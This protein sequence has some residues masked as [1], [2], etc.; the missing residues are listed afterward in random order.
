MSAESWKTIFD[1]GAVALL[2]L[3]FAF[4]AGAYFTGNIINTRQAEELRK[5]DKDLTS[6]KTELGGQQERAAQ[7]DERAS[8]IE[9]GNLQLRTELEN[10]KAESDRR[11]TELEIEQRRTAE[12]QESAAKA[13]LEL[14]NRVEM[15][16]RMAG[17][18]QLSPRFAEALKGKP[19]GTVDILYAPEDTEAYVF[20]IKVR[21]ALKNAGWITS[22]PKPIL[23]MTPIPRGNP[24]A[25][26]QARYGT[27]GPLTLIANRIIPLEETNSSAGAI[28]DA[29]HSAFDGIN[30]G[31][32]TTADPTLPDGHFTLIV[33]QK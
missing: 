32:F 21:G 27:S 14:Q 17:P 3:T 29:V 26:A 18:R 20:A 25:P 16:R 15:V 12:A 9:A 19:T 13:Q 10:A 33:G 30:W 8:Q 2:F 31:W 6:A 1:V 28:Q 24:N 22:G 11:Q 5:F 7:A 4:G 23:L